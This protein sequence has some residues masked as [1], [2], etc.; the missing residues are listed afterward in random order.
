[1]GPTLSRNGARRHEIFVRRPDAPTVSDAERTRTLAPRPDRTHG[2]GVHRSLAAGLAVTALV[3]LAGVAHATTPLPARADHSVY[4]AAH[5]LGDTSRLEAINTELM[6]KAGVA[7]VVVTVPRL[8]GETIGDLAVRVQHDW[9]VGVK[10]KDESAVIAVS[11]E[12]RKVF[13]ATGYGS[14]AYLPDGKVGA[15]RDQATPALHA[16]DYAG[17]VLVLDTEVARVAAAAH[18]VTLTGVPAVQQ[19]EA[20]TGEGWFGAIFFIVLIFLVVGVIAARHRRGGGG[21]GSG[22]GGFWLGALLGNLLSNLG[23]GGRGGGWGGGG[24]GD[25][26]GG[27]FGGFGGGSGGGGGA[28]GSF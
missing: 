15:I 12:D 25:S 28:G 3:A 23:R 8:E 20:D 9:G 19:R 13:I 6:Q 4:D 27:G 14:E 10:G 1:M 5:V 26:G 18:G 24:G 16:N 17:G 11:V 2:V 22:G 21:G 7:I